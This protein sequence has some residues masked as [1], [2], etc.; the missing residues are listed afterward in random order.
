MKI[1]KEN[2]INGNGE[3]EEIRFSAF[4]ANLVEAFIV[5]IND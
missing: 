4:E 3:I 1:E 5:F 2:G